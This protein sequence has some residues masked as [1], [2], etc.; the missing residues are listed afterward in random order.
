MDDETKDRLDRLMFPESMEDWERAKAEHDAAPREPGRYKVGVAGPPRSP[1]PWSGV[2]EYCGKTISDPGG[3]GVIFGEFPC[4]KHTGDCLPMHGHH[5][6]SCRGP[7]MILWRFWH[8]HTWGKVRVRWM[9]Y[10]WRRRAKR[11]RND[12]SAWLRFWSG[13]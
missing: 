8:H 3:N 1:E 5:A 4:D 6:F 10:K 7:R 13:K 9:S 2:C 11:E 12:P